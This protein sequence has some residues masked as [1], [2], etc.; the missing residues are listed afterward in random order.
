MGLETGTTISAL[1]SSNPLSTDERSKGDDHLRLIKA[2]LKSQFPG[3]GGVGFAIPITA[4][5]AELNF[6]HGVTSAI[7]EQLDSL[8][9]PIGGIVELAVATNPATLYGYGTWSQYGTGR[10]TVGIDLGDTDFDTI[11]ETGGE[12]THLLTSNESGLRSHVHTPSSGS[13]YGTGG[14]TVANG[15]GPAIQATSVAANTP[16]DASV[17]HNNLQPYIVVYRWVRTA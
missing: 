10:V 6:V 8:K 1:Q 4:T 12:K 9:I 14:S 7:Q 13:F 3:A 2:V 17:A 15:A 11:S 16:L 5:E